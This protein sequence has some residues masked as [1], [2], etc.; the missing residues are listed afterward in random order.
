MGN[1]ASSMI[2]TISQ[3]LFDQLLL[4]KKNSLYFLDL[5]KEY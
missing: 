3:M 1:S 2:L 5:G 4:T